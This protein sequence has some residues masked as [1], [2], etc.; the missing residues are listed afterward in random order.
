VNDIR[1]E[2]LIFIG[3]TGLALCVWIAVVFVIAMVSLLK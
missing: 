1:D 2:V 3:A